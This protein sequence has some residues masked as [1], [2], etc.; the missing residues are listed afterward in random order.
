[1]ELCVTFR[2]SL[3][4]TDRRTDRDGRTE[5]NPQ[6]ILIRGGPHKF[7]IP[8]ALYAAMLQSNKSVNY[9]SYID[10]RSVH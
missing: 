1:M 10:L 6:R 3:D 2:S 4:V 8:I 9:V 5:C 7:S